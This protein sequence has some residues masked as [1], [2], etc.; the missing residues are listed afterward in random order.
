M[1]LRNKLYVR[2][3]GAGERDGFATFDP[4]APRRFVLS[5]ERDPAALAAL[6]TYAEFCEPE[7]AADIEAWVKEI[8][9]L[10]PGELRLGEVGASN[11]RHILTQR[12]ELSHMGGEA[13]K[14][15]MRHAKGLES[16]STWPRLSF[17]LG[18][19]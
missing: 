11:A 15:T 12:V 19:T 18:E 7:L 10:V 17:L 9:E 1:R 5:P 8:K 6:M 13:K 4:E 16:G 3:L 2:N 14:R